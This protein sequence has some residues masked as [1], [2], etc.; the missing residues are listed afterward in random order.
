LDI[1][2]E[3]NRH[4][5]WIET[6][7]ALLGNEEMSPQQVEEIAQHDRCALGKWLISED[8]VAYQ[9]V[10]ELAGLRES[11]E[12]FHRLA[13]DLIGHL[14]EGREAEALELQSRFIEM[15]QKVIGCLYVLREKSGET[16]AN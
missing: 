2:Q 13:G 11:H 15:S 3:I 7:V 9:G 5:E 12:A 8:S 16:D 6:V 1:G 4:L 10:P 14:A